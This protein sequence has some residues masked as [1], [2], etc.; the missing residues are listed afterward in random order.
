VLDVFAGRKSVPAGGACVLPY[1]AEL[2]EPSLQ[3][4]LDH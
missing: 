4:L 1:P 3:L 2:L